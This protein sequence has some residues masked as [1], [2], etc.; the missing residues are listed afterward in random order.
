VIYGRNEPALVHFHTSIR[1]AL[2]VAA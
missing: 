1:D 2:G